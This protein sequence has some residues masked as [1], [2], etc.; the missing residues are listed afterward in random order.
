MRHVYLTTLFVC[1]ALFSILGLRGTKFTSPPMDVFPEWAFPG[2]KHQPKVRAQG[3]SAF[4]ADGRADRQPVEHTVMRG[5]L[6]ED[7]H[8]NRG[9][10]AAGQFARGFPA[11]LPVDLKL[12]E[13]GRERYGIYCAVCHGTTGFGDGITKQYGM[14]SIANANYHT[15]RLRQ[16]SEGEIFHT[17]TNGSQ[18]KNMLSYADKLTPDE[19]WAVVAYVRALQ[20][21]QQGTAAD[22]TDAAARQTLGLP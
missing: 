17:I 15:D 6:R 10:D 20:R 4:F 1:V 2:M 22:V 12:I 11:A 8:R 14:G 21:A 7:D 9:R 19:R 3:Q 5:M 18:S 13:R 16:M